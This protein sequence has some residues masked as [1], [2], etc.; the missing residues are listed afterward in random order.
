MDA[1]RP[2]SRKLQLSNPEMMVTWTTVVVEMGEKDTGY[3]C[4]CLF[5]CFLTSLL[6]YN[7]FALVC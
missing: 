5:V 4:F 1:G 6:E 2:V 7:C 3:I